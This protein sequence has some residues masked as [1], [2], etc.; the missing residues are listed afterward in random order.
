MKLPEID[1]AD[2]PGFI[3]FLLTDLGL[4]GVDDAYKVPLV[5]LEA[6]AGRI[7]AEEY[8]NVPSVRGAARMSSRMTQLVREE[9]IK[10]RNLKHGPS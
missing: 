8:G 9:V 4:Y 5:R 7:I 2:F 3:K 1:Q 6:I 10:Q